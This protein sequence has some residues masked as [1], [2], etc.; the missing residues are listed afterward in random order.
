TLSILSHW[1]HYRVRNISE[2]SYQQFK[3]D[4]SVFALAQKVQRQHR[5]LSGYEE[6]MQCHLGDYTQYAPL[7][8]ELSKAE[9]AASRSRNRLRRRAIMESLNKL[10]VGDI[11]DVQGSR[12][13]GTC[14]VVSAA[15]NPTNPRVGVVTAK[16]QL[17]RV[18]T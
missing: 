5:S 15:G 14:V 4:I 2:S 13:L 10:A 7:R 3:T 8:H 11:V 1:S 16:G 6:A 12:N 17:R 18:S 9:T